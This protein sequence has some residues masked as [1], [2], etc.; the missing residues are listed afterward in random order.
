[1]KEPGKLDMLVLK[2]DL[3]K[4]C[5]IAAEHS[6]PFWFNAQLYFLLYERA[7]VRDK[8]AKHRKMSKECRI[9]KLKLDGEVA[10]L[11]LWLPQQIQ[12]FNVPYIKETI[13]K[14]FAQ[15]PLVGPYK[16]VPSPIAS[17]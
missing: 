13:K 1:M 11:F 5:G 3:P 2:N 9:L 4:F 12:S 16:V 15:E 7:A 14:D 10:A 17:P 8:I 6:R